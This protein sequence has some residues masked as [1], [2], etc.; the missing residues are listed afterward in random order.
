MD[1]C[2]IVAS[3]LCLLCA[4]ALAQEA[5]ATDAPAEGTLARELFSDDFGRHSGLQLDG[6]LQMG[7]VR[8]DARFFRSHVWSALIN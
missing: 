5:T 6:Y 7:F 2:W 8:N 1:V 3:M 4:G